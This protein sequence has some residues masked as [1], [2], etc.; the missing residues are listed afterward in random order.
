[1]S[2][3]TL[4]EEFTKAEEGMTSPFEFESGV[5][6]LAVPEKMIPEISAG[7]EKPEGTTLNMPNVPKTKTVEV[8]EA[9]ETFKGDLPHLTP[10]EHQVVIDWFDK[11][12]CDP[13]NPLEVRTYL[14]EIALNLK[15]DAKKRIVPT[16]IGGKEQGAN[17]GQE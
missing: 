14:T 9:P 10:E 11:Q 2:W 8:V 12:S 5:T 3:K 17:N 7:A 16:E 1:M 4:T 6:V 13:N 15:L